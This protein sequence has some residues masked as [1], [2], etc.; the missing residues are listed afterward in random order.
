MFSQKQLIDCASREV[1]QRLRVY[2]RLV[3]GQRMTQADADHQIAMMR[4]IIDV[5][6][7]SSDEAIR[8][9]QRQPLKS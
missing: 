3:E 4:A 5:L 6:F 2:P 8:L 7:K 9:A 1:K